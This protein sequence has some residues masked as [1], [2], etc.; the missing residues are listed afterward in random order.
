[1]FFATVLILAVAVIIFHKQTEKRKDRLA[2]LTEQR[3]QV[4][5]Q[6]DNRRDQARRLSDLQA[7]FQE[8][9]EKLIHEVAEF[10]SELDLLR[11]KTRGLEGVRRELNKLHEVRN[12]F[13]AAEQTFLRQLENVQWLVRSG[14]TP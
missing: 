10:R 1:M 8:D 2:Q 4:E 7:D 6:L 9:R 13:L 5:R 14:A 11:V 3:D 12:S